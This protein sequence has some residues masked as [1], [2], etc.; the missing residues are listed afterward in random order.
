MTSYVSIIVPVYNRAA[1]IRRCIDSISNQTYRN[2]EIIIVDDGSTDE[3]PNICR[4]LSEADSRIKYIR[5]KNEGSGYARNDGINAAQGE[6][7]FFVDS[8]DF[9]RNDTIEILVKIAYEN[10]AD[11]VKCGYDRGVNTDFKVKIKNRR[12]VIKNN[13]DVFR[14]R[15]INIAVWGKLYRRE[16]LDGIRY[17]QET[18]YDDEFFTYRCIYNADKIV[19]VNDILYYNYISSISIMRQDRKQM[20][21]AVIRRAYKERVTYFTGLGEKELAGISLK[22]YAIRIMLLYCYAGDYSDGKIQKKGL[23]GLY[24]KLYE[25]SIG[26][27]SGLKETLSMRLFYKMPNVASMLIRRVV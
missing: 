22:E 24:K 2:L 7:L 11:I 19:I 20:P 27:A 9:I 26:Y 4:T 13:V 5:K 18:L 16:V 1:Y 10:Q 6:F 8:D 21:V 15:E 12:I 17:P 25:R 14:S 3:T 23:F